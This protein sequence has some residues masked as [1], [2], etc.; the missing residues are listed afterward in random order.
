MPPVRSS[1]PEAQCLQDSIGLTIFVKPLDSFFCIPLPVQLGKAPQ[2]LEPCRFRYS[3]AHTIAFG[4][5]GNL[6]EAVFQV[7]VRPCVSVHAGV[8]H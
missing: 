6:M 3:E 8:V 7:N 2:H 4:K 1:N 5:V